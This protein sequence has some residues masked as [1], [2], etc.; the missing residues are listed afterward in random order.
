MCIVSNVGDYYGRAFPSRWPEIDLS[1][2]TISAP[3][4]RQEFDAL[5]KEVE[6]LKDLTAGC[7]E[8]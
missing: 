3:V 1:R 8:V 7:Q 4:S 6:E 5:K 2:A